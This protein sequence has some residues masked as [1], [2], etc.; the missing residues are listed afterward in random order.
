MLLLPSSDAARAIAHFVDRLYIEIVAQSVP[1]AAWRDPECAAE[2]PYHAVGP[3]LEGLYEQMPRA[4]RV[5]L[6]GGWPSFAASVPVNARRMV[7]QITS[8]VATRVEGAAWMQELLACGPWT[9][10]ERGETVTPPRTAPASET[11]R[12]AAGVASLLAELGEFTNRGTPLT[13]GAL[14][15][16]VAHPD[17]QP[18]EYALLAAARDPSSRKFVWSRVLEVALS[19]AERNHAERDAMT[20]L[21]A[22]IKAR[23]EFEARGLS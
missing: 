12:S 13:V 6:Q 17:A 20:K 22:E 10:A 11:L 9:D 5:A 1:R 21:H 2:P 8:I 7:D 14:R 16:R 19:I 15:H 4:M 23:K 3:S 18:S